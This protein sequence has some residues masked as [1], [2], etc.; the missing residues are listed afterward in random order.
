[1]SIDL[2]NTEIGEKYL[3]KYVGCR[4]NKVY[5]IT[6]VLFVDCGEELDDESKVYCN[7]PK[8]FYIVARMMMCNVLDEHYEYASGYEHLNDYAKKFGEDASY[9]TFTSEEL[10]I[11][12]NE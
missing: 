6:S 12:G 1:M 8:V 10:K 9:E 3:D 7:Y 11:V 5:R 2:A 4:D